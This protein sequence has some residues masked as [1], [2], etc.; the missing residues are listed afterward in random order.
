MVT[1]CL[2]LPAVHGKRTGAYLPPLE[3][4]VIRQT[5]GVWTS[6][7]NMLVCFIL[8]SFLNLFILC[9]GVHCSCEPSCGCWELNFRTSLQAPAQRFIYYYT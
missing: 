6:L 4:A 5:R 2:E 9:M 3:W 8:L 7:D 1:G